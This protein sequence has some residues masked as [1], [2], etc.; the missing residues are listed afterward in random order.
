MSTNIRKP[1]SQFICTDLLKKG[2]NRQSSTGRSRRW[3]KSEKTRALASGDA[4]PSKWKKGH[5]NATL[6]PSGCPG[7]GQ[8]KKE[9]RAEKIRISNGVILRERGNG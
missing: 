2:N 3:G 9:G 5:E 4:G 7:K 1:K 6:F 8:K